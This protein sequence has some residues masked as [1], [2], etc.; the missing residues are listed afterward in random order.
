[1]NE[2]CPSNFALDAFR[3]GLDRGPAD[4]VKSCRRCNDWLAAQAQLEDQ[5]A[6]VAIPA[7]RQRPRAGIVKYLLGLGLPVAVGASVLLLLVRPKPPTETAKGGSIPVE[8][9]RMRGGTLAWLPPQGSLLP[10]DSVRFFVGRNDVEDRYVLIGSVD[11]SEQLS[12]FY[13]AHADGCSVSLPGPGEALAGS[14]VIDGAAGPERI[15]VV[16]SHRPLCWSTIAEP[17]RRLALGAPVSGALAGA[18]VHTTRLL[19]PKQVEAAH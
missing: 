16:V 15:V 1:M 7:E 14:I 10:D 19:L 8:I 9:A 3:L 18:D 11:G 6:P 17:V 5:V 2:Q 13:P 4:H 12:R